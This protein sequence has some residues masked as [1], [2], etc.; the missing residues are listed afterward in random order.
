MANR[1]RT[2][3]ERNKPSRVATDVRRTGALSQKVIP[4]ISTVRCRVI[5]PRMDPVGRTILW[6][7]FDYIGVVV[8]AFIVRPNDMGRRRRNND[9]N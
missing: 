6:I 3:S 8:V 7:K 5:G 4:A 9:S 2:I 1:R